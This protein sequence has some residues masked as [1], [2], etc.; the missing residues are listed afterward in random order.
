M[1]ARTPRRVAAVALS[2]AIVIGSAGTAMAT[3]VQ[4]PR[5]VSAGAPVPPGADQ[6]LG[7]AQTLAALGAVLKPVTDLLTG[8]LKGGSPADVKVLA[9]RATKALDAVKTPAPATPTAPTKPAPAT[10]TAPAKPDTAA[11]P[12]KPGTAAAPAL[13][14]APLSLGGPGTAAGPMDVKGDAVAALKK[15]LDDLLKAVTSANAAG[16]VP[17]AT[18]VVTNLVGLVTA[19]VVG[20]GLPAPKLSGLPALPPPPGGA[21]PVSAPDLP[22]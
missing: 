6:V 5:P 21:P 14:L 19:T 15:S 12:A 7:Q 4:P 20:G 1:R 22:A 3:D 2:T 10:P 16:V 17:A 9:D 13:T 11:A 8:V 18:G